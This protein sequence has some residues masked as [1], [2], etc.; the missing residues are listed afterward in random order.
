MLYFR[1][2]ERVCLTQLRLCALQPTLLI[3]SQTLATTIK[4][5]MFLFSTY[6]SVCVCVFFKRYF[7]ILYLCG[8]LYVCLC[9]LYLPSVCRDQKRLLE[10]LW[11][12]LWVLELNRCPLEE[13]RMLLIL[14]HHPSPSWVC[15]C[16]WLFYWEQTL[17][18]HPCSCSWQ[19][20]LL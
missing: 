19:K 10:P 2:P 20:S 18:V 11:A 15:F 1:S 8:G 6:Y 3:S 7:L 12:M 14:S 13:Q 16:D 17:S 4:L 5:L 9:T